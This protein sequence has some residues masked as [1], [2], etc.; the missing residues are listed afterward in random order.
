MVADRSV[1]LGAS[2]NEASL[3]SEA[4]G[5]LYFE[6]LDGFLRWRAALAT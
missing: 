3:L 4:A 5:D 1:G 6:M 2:V